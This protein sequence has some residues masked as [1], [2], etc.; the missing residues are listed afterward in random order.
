M[1]RLSSFLLAT[2]AVIIVLIAL[3]VSGLRLALPYAA[4][5]RPQ[6][7]AQL[8]KF[9]GFPIAVG[10]I[11]AS[12]QSFGPIIDI[13]DIS[14]H[15][16]KGDIAVQRI[17]I[18]L[19]VWKS[20]LQ[21]RWQFKELTFYGI[22]ASSK[23]P[24]K[25][26][27]NDSNSID[28]D[29][30]KDIF[31]RQFDHFIVHDSHIAFPTEQGVRIQLDIPQLVWFNARK[32]HQAEGKI[33]VVTSAGQRGRAQ[34]RVDLH[35]RNDLL[36]DGQVY[37]QADDIELSA[38]LKSW[39]NKQSELDSASFNMVSWLNV[40]NGDVHDGLLLLNK[41]KL[42]WLFDKTPHSLTLDKA[43]IKIAKQADG[44]SATLPT[45]DF[46]TDGA[47]WPKGS[48]AVMYQQG[49]KTLIGKDNPGEI[50]VRAANLQLERV[51]PLLSIFSLLSPE[52]DSQLQTMQPQG[53]ITRLA[54]DI[55]L[56]QPESSRFQAAWHNL[57]W[58]PWQSSIPGVNRFSGSASGTGQ[59]AA[60][61][62]ILND[63]I[64]PYGDMFRAPL[65][66]KKASGYT[67][68]QR[69][70]KEWTLSGQQIDVQANALW[71]KGDFSFNQPKQGE[72]WLSILAGI[73][74]YDAG[75]A[76]RYFPIPLMGEHLAN[77][78]SGAI[79][80]GNVDNATL[81]YAG[82]PHLFPYYH[83]EGQFQV[84]VPLQ[85]ATFWFQPDWAPLTHLNATLNF[86][87]DGLWI[88]GSDT[89]LGD[90]RGRN[91]HAEIPAYDKE[92]LFIDA[93]VSGSGK[94]VHDYFEKTPLK[95]SVASALEMVQVGGDVAAKLHL[96]IPLDGKQTQATGDVTLRDNHVF[97]KP[98]DSEMKQVTGKF[99]FDNGA[100]K[101]ATLTAYWLG[102]PVNV[103]FST[104]PSDKDYQVAVDVHGNWLPAKIS[105]IPS[106]VSRELSGNTPWRAKV[107]IN[108]PHQASATYRVDV[109]ADLRNIVS[110]LPMPL[111]KKAHSALDFN[112]HVVGDMN[113]LQLNGNLGPGQYFN[114][115]INLSKQGV[116][117]DRFVWRNGVSHVP[118][119]PGHGQAE[120]DLPEI[121]GEGL[122]A[123]L[124]PLMNSKEKSA[125]PSA[126]RY[127]ARI[128]LETPQL[129][130]AGQQWHQLRVR[131]QQQGESIQLKVK[132]REIDANTQLADRH[133][134][135]ANIAYLYYN[136]I[137]SPAAEKTDPQSTVSAKTSST[138]SYFGSWPTMQLRC[139]ECWMK[140]QRL[141]KIEADLFPNGDQLRLSNGLIDTGNTRVT[142]SG[143]WL[144]QGYRRKTNLK[145]QFKGDNFSDSVNYFGYI[146]PVRNAHY[147]IH[148][149]LSWLG[150]PW[151]PDIKTLN[152]TAKYYFSKGHIESIDTGRAGRL[153][154][155]VSYDSLLRKLRLDF[156]DVFGKGF[157]FDSI[158]DHGEFKHGVYYSDNL[159]VDGLEADIRM[160][161]NV[162]LV[163]HKINIYATV[164]P[165]VSATLGVAMAF[166][167]NPIV[168]VGVFVASKLLSPLWNE[169]TPIRYNITGDL[170]HPNVQAAEH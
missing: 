78:L 110:Q 166:A 8:N 139:Q 12:W 140:G 161:G 158:K 64:L 128:T 105:E 74:V 163:D 92:K 91:I 162:N 156:H 52:Q 4:Q 88:N 133:H 21:W 23:V 145:A 16:K 130:L 96:D 120:I 45:H 70:E 27:E 20:L 106:S 123:A 46:I 51:S 121:D 122:L 60:L 152:G 155:F 61:Y 157:Y 47:R 142:L 3:L 68:F 67:R 13:R 154:R 11:Q 2:L 14:V 50:R 85:D 147:N 127:P 72:P 31:L 55:P 116:A 17:T 34:L 40:V 102:Q 150:V 138:S 59:D 73:R 135:R 129:T 76:W 75:Q 32:R 44:W 15:P 38:W 80:G 36:S 101:S 30:L 111:N 10:D 66:V 39:V 58:Q 113:S 124:M 18:A 97:I 112:T 95:D 153:L 77:Y 132:G 167:V 22:Q 89:H 33:S 151:A 28:I 118:A 169:I 62:F 117:L 24:F 7:V 107:A 159:R 43:E 143:N 1:R 126:F 81:V 37:L 90:V 35:D 100:L 65:V 71:A 119:L 69:D 115:Q 137:W 149:D 5:Y 141:G 29:Q 168:G 164:I 19:N 79:K 83:N 82:N 42:S 131:A 25:H 6:I 54:A 63:S 87:N 98:I 103:D 84:W 125:K 93:D 86:M 104:T 57:S 49:D 114:G 56:K 9:S 109:K 136:P 26:K 148:L 165:E 108:L 48:V 146:T 41:G 94:S 144:Q 160:S 53:E 170:D 99:S 134:L